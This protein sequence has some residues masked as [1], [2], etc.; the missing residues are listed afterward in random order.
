M[1]PDRRETRPLWRL[2]VVPG[3]VGDPWGIAAERRS[4]TQARS[5]DVFW[6]A[7]HC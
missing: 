7:G 4:L 5:G 2:A 1:R 3:L 6:L